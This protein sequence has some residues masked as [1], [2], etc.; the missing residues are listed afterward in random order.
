MAVNPQTLIL[1]T[2]QFL[3][4]RGGA[5]FKTPFDNL[6]ENVLNLVIDPNGDGNS[7]NSLILLNDLRDVNTEDYIKERDPDTGAPTLVA[8]RNLDFATAY[9]M[10]Q[11]VDGSVSRADG[12]T[13][14]PEFVLADPK[15]VF[16]DVAGDIGD[17][18]AER[19]TKLELNALNDVTTRLGVANNIVEEFLPHVSGDSF[20]LCVSE[21]D[22]ANG[23]HPDYQ[24]RSLSGTIGDLFGGFELNVEL[25]QLVDINPIFIG[26][27]PLDP[28][29]PVSVRLEV[30]DEYMKGIPNA[31]KYR[32]VDSVKEFD[33][34]LVYLTGNFSDSCFPYG[35]QLFDKDGNDLSIT[36]Q[37][38]DPIT[39][40]P[41]GWYYAEN[42]SDGAG[43]LEPAGI[44]NV[45]LQEEAVGDHVKLG[46]V[47]VLKFKDTVLE[48]DSALGGKKVASVGAE[49]IPTNIGITDDG[50]L[51][52]TVPN[53][54]TFGQT[55][56][57]VGD[58]SG[59]VDQTNAFFGYT[60][61]ATLGDPVL[62]QGPGARETPGEWNDQ[63]ANGNVSLP[64]VGDFYVVRFVDK[65]ATDTGSVDEPKSLTATLKW[66]DTYPL[67]AGTPPAGPDL[68]VENG[69]IVAFGAEGWNIIGTVDTETIAQD[70]QD[71]TERG[72]FTDRGINLRSITDNGLLVGAP[73]NVE[74]VSVVSTVPAGGVIAAQQIK[75][76]NIDFDFIPDLTTA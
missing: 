51:Y 61:D 74:D 49:R 57:I 27:G 16:A 76:N 12:E 24:P 18:V 31:V 25:E 28:P 47:R 8:N 1:D 14:K 35:G 10:L 34:I 50:V 19:F 22:A 32:P 75:V 45:D 37:N 69:D 43:G 21:G 66:N 73:L 39:Q 7:N 52:A 42:I 70:L 20:L 44:A 29:T 11:Y 2:D 33:D 38:G 41:R 56:D 15:K 58:V 5:T 13:Q 4:N 72:N 62:A 68:Q 53:T 9:W 63:P 67:G 26:N 23:I 54:L 17:E 46:G 60:S 40:L 59:G 48:D 55:V 71:V 65:R 64:A 3:L 30:T 6:A 36:N